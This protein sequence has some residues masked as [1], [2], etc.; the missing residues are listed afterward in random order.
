MGLPQIHKQ[1]EDM[2]E[3]LSGERSFIRFTLEDEDCEVLTP[4]KHYTVSV[5][6]TV[7]TRRKTGH[8]D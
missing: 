6:D 8:G 4:K 2:V 3:A 7:D 1:V 5:K